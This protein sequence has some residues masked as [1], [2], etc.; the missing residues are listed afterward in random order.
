MHSLEWWS[1]HL[2]SIRETINRSRC[3]LVCTSGWW[4]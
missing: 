3:L 4:I 1:Y 2:Q